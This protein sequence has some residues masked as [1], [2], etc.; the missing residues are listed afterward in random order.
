MIESIHQTLAAFGY[1]HP[2]HPTLIH[3]PI[4]MVM[5][6]FLF[7]LAAIIFR[8]T[9]L[10]HTARHCVILGLLTA[11]PAALLGLMDWLHFFGGAMLLPFK[12]K[13]IL[14][15][16]L[17]S[18]LFLAVILGFFGERFQKL[19]L[20]L[21][22]ICLIT[23]I[24]LGYFG[25]EIVYGKKTAKRIELGDVAAKGVE[26]FKK[27]CAACHLTDSTA[28]KIGP[29]LMGMFQ[30]DKFPISG[31]A[32]TEANFRSLLKKPVAKMPPFGHLP[33]KEVDALIEYLN[34][35]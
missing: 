33:D 34:T 24:G 32:A 1:T 7:A 18:F 14:A 21:Y 20:A 5:G 16:I 9:G 35:L 15:V 12:M 23:T 28:T 8:R 22:V 19:I 17:V 25:G 27:N 31:N 4:G 11:I 13:I 29:G 6:A 30:K 26:I 10:A 2:L 3:L